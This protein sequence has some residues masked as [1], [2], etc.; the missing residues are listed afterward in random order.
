MPS[1]H[2]SFTVSLCVA[3]FLAEGPSSSFAVA[4]VVAALAIIDALA[5][6]RT[7][8]EHGR[9]LNQLVDQLP[10]ESEYSFPILGVHVGHTVAEIVAGAAL[11]ASIALLLWSL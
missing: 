6:R 10:P 3:I 11:G 2:A 1:M 9:V 7:V 4:A 8:G 5:L